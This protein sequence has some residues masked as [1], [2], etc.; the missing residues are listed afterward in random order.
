M[1][2][3][4][5]KVFENLNIE[6]LKLEKI[7]V[8]A[9]LVYKVYSK[10]KNYFIK[11]YLRDKNE[12]LAEKLNN[13]YSLMFEKNIPVPKV[14]KYDNSK[15]ELDY[16]YIIFSEVRGEPLKNKFKDMSFEDKKE[17]FY[18]FGKVL[19]KINSI[20]FDKFGESIDLKNV[21]KINE[22][23]SGPFNTWK[24]MHQSLISHRLSFF[25]NTE[26]ENLINPIKYYFKTNSNLIDYSIK[27][28]L[29]HEDLNQ[30]NIFIENNKIS[31]IID[32]DGAI[33]GHNE[34]ELMR[35]EGANFS[36]KKELKQVFLDGYES[37][38]KLDEGYEK[39]RS[40]YFLSRYLVHISCLLTYKENYIK[41]YSSAIESVK[42]EL[43]KILSGKEI[44]F[45]KNKAHED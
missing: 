38:L 10:N 23:N 16:V 25:E 7:N 40:F 11:I 9:D 5:K 1:E 34:E 44:D 42:E 41:N 33:I 4:I 18:D 6:V 3:K 27:A 29:L 24:E 28:R 8:L 15:K 32:F 19:A 12:Y 30:K 26:L 20:T 22:I 13:L 39:R 14:I 31:G 2:N 35:T 45:T 37:I 21:E 36:D 17:F 43:N